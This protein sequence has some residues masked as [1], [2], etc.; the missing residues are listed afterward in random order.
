MSFA[1][2]YSQLTG[3]ETCPRRFYILNVAKLVREPQSE[4]LKWG[5]RVHKG[6]EER[7][8]RNVPLSV[9]LQAYEPLAAK[10]MSKQGT[11][12]AERKLAISSAY[13]PTEWMAPN[14]WARAIMDVSV[15]N[16][17]KMFV[18][19]WKTGNPKPD[20]AQLKMSAAMAFHHHPDVQTVTTAFV[21]I[22]TNE[23]TAETFTRENIPEIWQ[24]F[25]PRVERLKI[26][27]AENKFPPRP[28]GLCR[29][30]CPVGEKHCE[31]WGK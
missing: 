17:D 10:I 6:L 16:G 31:F 26:A 12:Y 5:N 2:S 11:K 14:V 29:K 20:S 18:G 13:K 9:D 22:K 27:K 3:F 19:D 21:W 7:I 1:W 8:A 30:W 25:A 23:V 24:E 15:V 28:S 4:E